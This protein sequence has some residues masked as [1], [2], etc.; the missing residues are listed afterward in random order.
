M[1][2]AATPNE[3]LSRL[4]QGTGLTYSFSNARTVAISG[5]GGGG[6]SAA[7]SADGTVLLDPVDVSGVGIKPADQPYETPGSSAFISSEQISRVSPSSPGDIFRSTPGVISAGNRTT[8]SLNV[9]IRGLQGSDRVRVLID[10]TQQNTTTYRGYRGNDDR[11]SVDPDLISSVTVEKGPSS[12]PYGS[13]A[14][15]GVVN[16]QTLTAQDI[17]SDGKTYGFR[18]K[19]ELGSNTVK[20]PAN[21]STSGASAPGVP[22]SSIYPAGPALTH[23]DPRDRPD[24]FNGEN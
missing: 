14:M 15:G 1:S 4:L 24:F 6:N 13:G 23:I 3:A 21:F 17:V 22:P 20:P 19:G 12:G 9:N 10:G 2:D 8:N 5:P 18:F 16:M 7:V 11:T